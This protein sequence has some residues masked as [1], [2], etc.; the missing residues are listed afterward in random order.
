MWN[1][2]PTIASI[3]NL[4]R[5]GFEEVKTPAAMADGAVNVKVDGHG[6][7]TEDYLEANAATLQKIHRMNVARR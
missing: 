1:N 3:S 2:S 7:I 6:K 4:V 5:Y